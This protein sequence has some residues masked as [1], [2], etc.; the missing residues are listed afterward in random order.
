MFLRMNETT[1]D[2]DQSLHLFAKMFGEFLHWVNDID[3]QFI[4]VAQDQ[5]FKRYKEL[6]KGKD[7]RAR[8]LA[9]YYYPC[10]F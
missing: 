4:T 8:E 9:A 10:M 5:V 2:E 1:F 3:Y 7:V 6:C